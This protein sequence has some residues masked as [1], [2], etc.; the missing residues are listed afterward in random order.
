MRQ[1]DDRQTTLQKMYRKN[2]RSRL[3][4]VYVI[5]AGFKYDAALSGVV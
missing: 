1:S 4:V 2:R 5:R 3:L